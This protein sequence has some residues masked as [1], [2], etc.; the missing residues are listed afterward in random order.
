MYV[1][2]ENLSHNEL[3]TKLG[4]LETAYYISTDRLLRQK[5]LLMI[6]ELK[7]ELMKRGK[8]VSKPI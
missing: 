6:D 1:N 3:I 7:I 2:L 5:M 4:R 8:Y